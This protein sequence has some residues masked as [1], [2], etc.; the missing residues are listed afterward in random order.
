MLFPD[1]ETE[2]E[3]LGGEGGGGETV[4]PAQRQQ[5]WNDL[6]MQRLDQ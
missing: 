2:R 4:Y 5:P 1:G 3:C 6:R